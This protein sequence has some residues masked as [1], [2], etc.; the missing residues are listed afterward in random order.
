MQQGEVQRVITD[1]LPYLNNSQLIK[2]KESMKKLL[3]KKESNELKNKVLLTR[4]F[5]SKRA[6][7]CSEK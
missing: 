7:G 5:S 4:Y 6:E 3:S 1:M 2:L